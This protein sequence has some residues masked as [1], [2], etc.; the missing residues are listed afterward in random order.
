MVA[1]GFVLIVSMNQGKLIFYDSPLAN[2][3]DTYHQIGKLCYDRGY[4]EGIDDTKWHMENHTTDLIRLS[5]LRFWEFDN[6]TEHV[7]DELCHPITR[8]RND[9]LLHRIFG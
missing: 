8:E 7:R 1:L 3:N 5:Y 4:F 2:E 6:T 9:E